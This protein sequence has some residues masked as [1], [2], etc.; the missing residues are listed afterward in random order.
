MLFQVIKQHIYKN[1]FLRNKVKK[2]H[3]QIVTHIQLSIFLNA[4]I[5]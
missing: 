3:F 4:D 1:T 5:L 2:K